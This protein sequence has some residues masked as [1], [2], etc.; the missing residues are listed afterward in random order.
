MKYSPTNPLPARISIACHTEETFV[1]LAAL[2]LLLEKLK[3]SDL[4]S[5]YD[6]N[7]SLYAQNGKQKGIH[8]A[9]FGPSLKKETLISK[10]AKFTIEKTRF[11]S[12]EAF[13]F[14]LNSTV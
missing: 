13:I 7:R 4:S 6:L 8:D 3:T 10:P 12:I 1:F 14:L 5:L 11:T 9:C 2:L